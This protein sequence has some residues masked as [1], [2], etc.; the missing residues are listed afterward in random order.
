MAVAQSKA[1]SPAQKAMLFAQATRQNLQPIP[2]SP[3]S[4]N[5]SVSF[6]IPK[7]RLL[8]STIVRIKGT[9]TAA[10]A[11]L[12]TLAPAR[13]APWNVLKQCR[14]Q[15]NNGFNPYQISG[16]GAYLYNRL[17]AGAEYDTNFALGTVGSV[18][19]AVNT[20][21]FM[22]DLAHVLND[23]DPVGMIMAQN[24]ET[25]ITVSLDLGVLASMYST[26]AVTITAAALTVTPIVE[27]YSIPAASEAIPDISVL[28]LVSE[29]NFNIP[30]VGAPFLVKLPVGLTYRKLIMNFEHAD[31]TGMT[32]DEIGNISIIFNQADTPYTVPAGFMRMRN[33]KQFGGKLPVGVIAFDLSYQGIAN[34]GGARDYIDTERL[35]EFWIQS[36]PSVVG[37]LQIVSETLARL[38]GV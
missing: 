4:E 30:S 24:Q 31:G 2:A 19:G 37:N 12:T 38:A 9:Y 1:L 29:Q 35:T 26:T 27:T 36:N 34:L 5:G 15:I 13:F 21:D 17:N 11:T 25:V 22:V 7:V 16:R 20:L 23:R 18:G 10:H 28:K 14:V 33:A 8:A 6:T 3:F 32:D